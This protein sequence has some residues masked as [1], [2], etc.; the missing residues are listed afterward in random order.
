MASRRVAKKTGATSTAKGRDIV[1]PN[2]GKAKAGG[3]PEVLPF[4]QSTINAINK[5]GPKGHELAHILPRE[6]RL[7]EEA[8]NSEG[9]TDPKTKIK[10]YAPGKT[11]YEKG[12]VESGLK[13]P[14][15]EN[16]GR[17]DSD[18][19]VA[20][21]TDPEVEALNTMR[22]RDKDRGFTSGFGPEITALAKQNDKPFDFVEYQGEKIPTLN[23]SGSYGDGPQGSGSTG[24]NIDSGSGGGGGES[25]MEKFIREHW[26]KV[27][28][29]KREAEAAAKATIAAAEK[30]ERERLAGLERERIAREKRQREARAR[31][32]IAAAEKKERER[33]AGIE[34]ERI[35]REKREK[36][37]RDKI[38]REKKEKAIADKAIAD[39]AIADKAIADKAIADKAIADKAI[40][41]KAITDAQQ[42]ADDLAEE[43]AAAEYQ[44]VL[45]AEN[46]ENETIQT[47]IQ[48]D[49]D[50][51][52]SLEQEEPEEPPPD[53][54]PG[55]EGDATVINDPVDDEIIGGDI[56]EDTTSINQTEG[57][58]PDQFYGDY[59]DLAAD[60]DDFLEGE[61]EYALDEEPADE[62]EEMQAEIQEDIDYTDQV[63]EVNNEFGGLDYDESGVTQIDESNGPVDVGVIQDA[64]DSA[65]SDYLEGEGDYGLEDDPYAEPEPGIMESIGDWVNDIVGNGEEIEIKDESNIDVDSDYLEGEGEYGLEDDPYEE[66]M[67]A[68]GQDITPEEIISALEENDDYLEGEGDYGV[69]DP[70]EVPSG[71]EGEFD[72]LDDAGGDN[73]DAPDEELLGG[74]SHDGGYDGEHGGGI[75]L[76]DPMDDDQNDNSEPGGDGGI[77]IDETDDDPSNDLEPV[78]DPT[79][80]EDILGGD[81][82]D[83]DYD[84]GSIDETDDDPTNDLDTY[85]DPIVPADNND[86][87]PDTTDPTIDVST[88]NLSDA[89]RQTLMDA[90]DKQY[91]EYA[92]TDYEALYKNEFT[93]DLDED[94]TAATKGLDYNFLTSGDRTEYNTKGD[95]VNDQ[96]DY[97]GDLLTGEQN[98]YLNTMSTNF[99][100][101]A[102]NTM[103]DWYYKNRKGIN[104]L[105]VADD[106]TYDFDFTDLDMSSY[107][108]PSASYDPEFY[109]AKN[110]DGSSLYDKIYEDPD[111]TY[112]GGIEG[113]TDPQE[114]F[115]KYP[116]NDN[117]PRTTFDPM[118]NV[119]IIPGPNDL[120]SKKNKKKTLPIY[121]Q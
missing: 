2:S 72:G 9:A 15:G 116:D 84:G 73:F 59:S 7:L 86:D 120:P 118:E 88:G 14:K 121:N 91:G 48:D 13:L 19:Q 38:A 117:D 44:A 46:A 6:G 63:D 61:G 94:F 90:L 97:L 57:P 107:S 35:A 85:D 60:G 89:D 56:G 55:G 24:G 66:T 71:Y 102:S 79:L 68:D 8:F 103:N 106:G 40:A 100:H 83:E 77:S 42:A 31:A 18:H 104:D 4:N 47:D 67:G 26:E 76:N 23:D 70:Y 49:I 41:D 50:Y 21:L 75:T 3:K 62:F 119:G 32:V 25:E 114:T 64:I 58:D 65:D 81:T 74:D 115:L 10:S 92:E 34:R 53:T 54:E 39:K 80:D 11:G 51:L 28:R 108:D 99:G 16:R 111:K 17:L 95:T 27:A 110:E 96:Q 12:V 1:S 20:V 112:Y 109:G 36:A 101:G 5:A 43:E 78:Y 22:W 52:E 29:E 98:D 87:G 33:L 82:Q 45:D 30:K 69:D 93:D 105:Q 37:A 113:G